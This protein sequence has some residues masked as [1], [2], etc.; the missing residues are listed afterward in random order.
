MRIKTI[1]LLLCMVASTG[2]AQEIIIDIPAQTFVLVAG[3]LDTPF[4][5]KASARKKPQPPAPTPKI[6]GS[7]AQGSTLSGNITWTATL[8]N[9]TGPV[10]FTID[11]GN[12]WT[13]AT[14]PFEYGGK[15]LGL[16]TSTLA[17]GNHTFK[18]VAGTTSHQV[19]A[20]INNVVA[21]PPPPPPPPD[22][23]PTGAIN[24]GA[25]ANGTDI[26]DDT[27]QIKN[28]VAAA[29]AQGKALYVPAGKF[30]HSTSINFENVHLVGDGP[31]SEFVATNHKNMG[32]LFMGNSPRVEGIKH[33][34]NVAGLVWSAPSDHN[35]C[36]IVVMNATNAIV[37]NVTVD[38][39]GKIGILNIASTG[40]KITNCYVARSLKDGIHNEYG[41]TNAEIAWNEVTDTGDDM[42]SVVSYDRAGEAMQSGHYI[43][44]NYV[45]DNY[46]ARGISV[47]GGENV[48][49]INNRITNSRVSGLY[50]WSEDSHQTKRVYNVTIEGNILTGC[51]TDT[52]SNWSAISIG[53][54]SIYLCDT[55]TLRNNQIIN[56]RR[57]AVNVKPYVKAIRF[58]GTTITGVQSGYMAW[59]IDPSVASQVTVV[60]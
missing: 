50:I 10:V 8:E 51:N 32:F 27:V 21:P 6:T 17:N 38:G 16:N 25:Y 18:V 23:I 13:E 40:S 4:N 57:D 42:I 47:V 5:I 56:P 46:Y 39:T 48:R 22:P 45:H 35:H 30:R 31:T 37:K 28:A 59:R 14:A 34:C 2:C 24:L 3:D 12:A 9:Q 1:C 53:G 7:I 54:R 11:G 49:I 20:S 36:G 15:L 52:G 26:I 41:S 19:T 58:E 60:P 55:V 33:S 43:H 44:D 29:K